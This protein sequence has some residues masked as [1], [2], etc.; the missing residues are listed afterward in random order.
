MDKQEVV[1][2]RTLLHSAYV[3]DIGN[4]Q[5]G[6]VISEIIENEKGE[7]KPN[8]RVFKSPTISFYITQPMYRTHKDKKEFESIKFLDEYRVSYKEKDKEIF[9]ALNGYVPNFISSQMRRELYQS[10]YLYGGNISIEA[11]VAIKYKKELLKNNKTPHS[12]TTG[13]F[14]I[15]MSL[16]KSSYGKL[17]LMVFTAENKVYLTMKRSFMNEDR[18]GKRVDVKIEDVEAAAHEI[19]DPLV[20]SLF[21]SNEGLSSYKNK[22]PFEYHFHVGDTE[23]DMIRWIFGKMHESKTS[24]IG[25]WNLGFDIPEII[26]VLKENNIPLE[27]ILADP[28]LK[29]LG[30]AYADYREDKRQVHHFTQKWHWLTATAHFQFVDS[31]ALYSYIRMV[32]GKEASYALDDILKK[33]N[34]GGKLKIDKTQELENLQTEDWH[35]EMLSRFFTYYALYAMWDGMALQLLEWINN[36][37]TAM[38]LLGDITPPKFFVN[39]TIRV[40]NTLYDEWLAKGYVLGTGVDVEGL[41]DEDLLT[42]GGA[43]LEPQNLVAKGLKLFLEWPNHSTHCYGWQNDFDFS[44][45][46]PTNTMVLNISKQ[47]KLGTM[48]GIRAPWVNIKYKQ[49]EAIEVLCSYLITPNANGVELGVDFFSLPDYE[50]MNELFKAKMNILV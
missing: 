33:F 39:Q 34:L 7:T 12:P 31:L 36:D 9:R 26:K 21:E 48:L 3:N 4:G 42:E 35:R 30:F 45:Q 2:S 17:P 16:L 46:Y 8:L 28:S 41:K 6:I 29:D 15:E 37:L 18:D 40:T 23:V 49:D 13:F 27:E 32:D 25:I 50:E 20:S 11:L 10:P 5:D 43:V 24:F 47:T 1:I 44:A 14:D 22:L 19:I 38:M